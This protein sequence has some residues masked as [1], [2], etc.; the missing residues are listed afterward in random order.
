MND[1]NLVEA[2]IRVGIGLIV[3]HTALWIGSIIIYII[4]RKS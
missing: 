2:I 1:S 4:F 3:T